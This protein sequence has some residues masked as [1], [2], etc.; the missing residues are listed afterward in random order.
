MNQKEVEA[1]CDNTALNFQCTETEAL[2]K[3]V[4]NRGLTLLN[5]YG[6]CKRVYFKIQIGMSSDS[7]IISLGIFR[8]CKG[9][10]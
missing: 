9:P 8:V 7:E 5:V 1:A 3:I 2:S 6:F 4:R 10:W